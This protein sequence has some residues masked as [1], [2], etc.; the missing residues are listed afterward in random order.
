MSR[1][2]LMSRLS[3]YR[4]DFE[5]FARDCLVIYPKSGTPI[6]LDISRRPAQQLYHR[7]LLE[8]LEKQQFAR[9]ILFKNRQ[10]GASSYTQGVVFWS[11]ALNQGTNGLVVAHDKETAEKLFFM[12]QTFYQHMPADLRPM[13]RHSTKSEL[14]FENPDSEDRLIHP[15]LGGG[16]VVATAR[17][18]HSG[19]G[20]TLQVCHLS[21]AARYENAEELQTAI[22]D[23]VPLGYQSKIIIESTAAFNAAGSTWF[24]ELCEDAQRPG[25]KT[26]WRFC[27][28]GWNY[29]PELWVALLP[30][31][32]IEPTEEERLLDQQF[33]DWRASVSQW[34]PYPKLLPEQLKWRRL[35]L[36]EYRN[37]VDLF[38]LSYPLT[39][40]EAWYMP[41]APLVTSEMLIYH[42]STCRPPLCRGVLKQLSET[43]PTVYGTADGPLS[44][45]EWPLPGEMYDIGVDVSEGKSQDYSAAVV[46]RRS[47]KTQVATY[48]SNTIEPGTEFVELLNGLGRLYNMAQVAVETKGPGLYTNGELSKVYPNLHIWRHRDAIGKRQLTTRTGWDT[49]PTSKEYLVGQVMD[50]LSNAK[51]TIRDAELWEEIS[52]YRCFGNRGYGAVKGHDD[53]V[54]AFMIALVASCDETTPGLETIQTAVEPHETPDPA[55]YDRSWDTVLVR[56]EQQARGRTPFLPYF[57]ETWEPKRG[58]VW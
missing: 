10:Q 1:E 33:E 28:A 17:N 57:D 48:R 37:N 30:E 18:I 47:T 4:R 6:P 35:K 53:L 52:R 9:L 14:R 23:A 42:R 21:E 12:A 7:A 27:F 13:V 49:T 54:M 46:L 3:Y 22:F 38:R 50:Y 8:Q 36:A 56:A 58:E 29:D 31:E 5:A 15:G 39:P 2:T 24:Q 11:C 20:R 16:I 43:I 19:A 41:G 55:T 26:P 34:C 51:V 44:M 40:E 25:S 32:V 45:W